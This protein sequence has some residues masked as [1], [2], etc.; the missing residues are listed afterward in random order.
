[1]RNAYASWT[2]VACDSVQFPLG[3][4]SDLEMCEQLAL[5]WRTFA[6]WQKVG[7]L[8]YG[9]LGE[10][11]GFKFVEPPPVYAALTEQ[12]FGCEGIKSL[13]DATD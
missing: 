4:S 12:A 6:I 13:P 8:W 3:R 11:A 1:M 10:L 2:C 5:Y 9:H 7:D